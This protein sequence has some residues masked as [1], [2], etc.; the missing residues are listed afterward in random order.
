MLGVVQMI[1]GVMKDVGVVV[2][3]DAE[4]NCQDWALEGLER[5]KKAGVVREDLE[6]ERV[7][8]WLKERW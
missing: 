3:E 5:L 2:G 4:W 6:R 1:D 7:K 8:A